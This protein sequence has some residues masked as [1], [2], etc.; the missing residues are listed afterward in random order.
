MVLENLLNHYSYDIFTHFE[1]L[2][3]PNAEEERRGVG[4]VRVQPLREQDDGEQQLGA[5][6][7]GVEDELEPG[8]LPL[9]QQSNHSASTASSGVVTFN[10]RRRTMCDTSAA[11]PSEEDTELESDE[12]AE[13]QISFHEE[14]TDSEFS[15]EEWHS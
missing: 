14:K 9:S 10:K 1:H 4:D 12:D 13:N 15:F 7:D 8:E 6:Q 11:G 2:E 5:V 3:E